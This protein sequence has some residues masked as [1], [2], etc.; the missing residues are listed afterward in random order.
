MEETKKSNGLR[1]FIIILVVLII[2]A[3]LMY[4]LIYMFPQKFSTVTTK[5]EKEVTV[6][7]NGIADAVDNVYDAVV[8]VSSYKDSKLISSGTGFV[9]KSDDDTA[10]ILTNHH[11]ISS[12]N[13]VTVTF[14]NGNVEET[15]IIGSN[16]YSDIA[17]L[18]LK[19]SK[20]ISVASIGSSEESRVGD[21]VFTVGAPLAST[22]SW[23]VTRGILSGKDRMIEVSTSNSQNN[24]YVMKVLQTDA[25]I[26]AGNSGGPLCNA[27]G[28]IIG[29]T[30]LKLVSSGIEGMGFAIPIEDA[31]ST[32]NAIINKESVDTPYIGITMV[33]VSSAYYYRD[34]YE[35]I[36]DS[37]LSSGVIV[38]DVEKGSQAEKAGL[39]SNDIITKVGD[40][41]VSSI[42]Y[43]RYALYQH[44]VGDKVEF[45]YYRDGKKNTTT[46]T[47]GSNKSTS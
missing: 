38:V 10:Y 40:I 3:G 8:V 2:G 35:L 27:S 26:N 11:V 17:V 37:G 34:Y 32:A 42:A 18:S 39:K 21:T 29:I 4:G 46:V 41:D 33:D 12:A 19:A 16:Q 44:K 45:T 24:D 7:D 36:K 28:K 13:K 22:Y 9:F 14:T 31:L 23:T 20:T 6:N 25:A 47:I 5:L 15:Q 43:L 1:N 30:S